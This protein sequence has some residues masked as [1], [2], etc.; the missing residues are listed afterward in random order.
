MG[1]SGDDDDDPMTIAHV[2]IPPPTSAS[3]WNAA[4]RS[5]RAAISLPV[6]RSF[7]CAT[8]AVREGNCFIYFL[9]KKSHLF[10]TQKQHKKYI[11]LIHIHA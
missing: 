2:G 11:H 6:A 8:A 5:K 4:R 10:F 7:A 3:R 1:W 9:R